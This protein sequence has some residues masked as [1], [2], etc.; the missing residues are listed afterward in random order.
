MS[1]DKTRFAE[2]H[3]IKSLLISHRGE[4]N[5]QTMWRAVSKLAV[6]RI[7]G[8]VASQC[9][10]CTMMGY[11]RTAE[12]R[13]RKAEFPYLHMITSTHAPRFRV[14]TLCLMF[15]HEFRV[16]EAHAYSCA[17]CLTAI[18][19]RYFGVVFLRLFSR[20]ERYC[21]RRGPLRLALLI[22]RKY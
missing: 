18:E 13:R 7:C 3:K 8:A 15:R 14:A 6:R 22:T 19:E 10:I 5:V 4:T 1:S 16:S 2:A 11:N 20:I 12:T 21:T 17:V 9:M